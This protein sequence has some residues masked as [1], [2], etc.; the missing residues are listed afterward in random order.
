VSFE[1]EPTSSGN[2]L[3]KGLVVVTIGLLAFW[4]VTG[5]YESIVVPGYVPPST[6]TTTLVVD[7]SSTT[8]R[9]PTT[10]T[11]PPVTPTTVPLGTTVAG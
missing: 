7:T 6:T 3:L 8:I 4:A 10:T 5:G 9:F 1:N 11:L 2:N